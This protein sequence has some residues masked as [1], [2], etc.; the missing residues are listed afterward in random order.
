MEY[1][2]YKRSKI[3]ISLFHVEICCNFFSFVGMQIETGTFFFSPQGKLVSVQLYI[4]YV[5]ILLP[6]V[7]QIVGLVI[8]FPSTAEKLKMSKHLVALTVTTLLGVAVGG[9]VL[10]KGIQRRRNKTSHVTRQQLPPPPQP[11]APGRGELPAPE[12][13]QPHSSAPRA[14]WEERILKA[15]VVTVSQEEE[16]DQIEPLLRRELKDFPVLGIDC[17]WVSEKAKIKHIFSAFPARDLDQSN[18]GQ[19]KGEVACSQ[20]TCKQILA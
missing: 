18:R 5:N 13:D 4:L 17:E 14:S 6:F 11:K 12:E 1:R 16:W 2:R 7:L 10:W 3:K 15:K 19:I 9:F 8:C 20:L